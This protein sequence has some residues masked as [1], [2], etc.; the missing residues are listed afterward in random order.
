MNMKVTAMVIFSQEVKTLSLK[1]KVSLPSG[2]K[3][4]VILARASELAIFLS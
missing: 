1:N 3:G 2:A 4:E